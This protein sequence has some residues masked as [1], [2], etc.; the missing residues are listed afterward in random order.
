MYLYLLVI[1]VS[2]V[3]FDEKYLFKLNK[4]NVGVGSLWNVGGNICK[5]KNLIIKWVIL[6]FFINFYVFFKRK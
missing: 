6:D 1:W 3:F 4:F 5:K 2:F